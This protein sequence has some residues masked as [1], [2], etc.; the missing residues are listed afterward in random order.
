MFQVSGEVEVF[1]EWK[2]LSSLTWVLKSVDSDLEVKCCLLEC[3]ASVYVE[4]LELI[5]FWNGLVCV[6]TGRV[7]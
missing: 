4:C 7:L 2:V 3:T 1:F 6:Y 5:C